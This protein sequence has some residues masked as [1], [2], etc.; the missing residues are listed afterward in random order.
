MAINTE[1]PLSKQESKKQ[2]IVS[3]PKQKT[4]FAK[5]SAKQKI[6]EKKDSKLVKE[7]SGIAEKTKAKVGEKGKE[8]KVVK[9]IKTEAVINSR[10]LPISTKYSVA[11][12]KFIKKKKINDAIS[13]LE[14][15]L[16]HKKSVPMKG[17]IPHRKGKGMMSGRY[18]EKPTKQFIELLKSL[19]K[20]SNAN[21]LIDPVIVEAIAN[22]GSRPFGKFG[23]VRKKRTN[24]TIKAK[25]AKLNK[26]IKK[27]KK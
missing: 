15:V 4:D 10:N 5:V 18:P 3:T 24:L 2:K 7:K 12:C 23:R 9:V 6:D 19:L 22:I 17:E 20:N 8:K 1:K 13:D 27:K 11:I 16:V 26:N 25:N 14:Q 21:G